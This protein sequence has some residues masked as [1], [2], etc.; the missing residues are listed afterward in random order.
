MPVVPCQQ[1]D[2]VLSR[3]ELCAKKSMKDLPLLVLVS[4]LRVQNYC[5]FLFH[6][7]F[8]IGDDVDPI[9]II[10]QSP[11]IS[12]KDSGLPSMGVYSN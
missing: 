3:R 11:S 6:N 7:Y 12:G 10:S 1:H 5:P 2:L 8:F 9:V 4:Q